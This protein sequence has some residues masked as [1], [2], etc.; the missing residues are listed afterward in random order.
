VGYQSKPPP[1]PSTDSTLVANQEPP[2]R[3]VNTEAPKSPSNTNGSRDTALPQWFEAVEQVGKF[4]AG[5]AIALYILG[6]LSVNGYLLGLG[7]SDFSLVRARFIYTG[8][9]E[10][11]T[12]AFGYFLPIVT[13]KKVRH[14]YRT[15]PP[16]LRSWRLHLFGPVFIACSIVIPV[17][18]ISLAL[19]VGTDSL[20]GSEVFYGFCIVNAGLIT[21]IFAAIQLNRIG[22]TRHRQAFERNTAMALAIVSLCAIGVLYA[23]VFMYL[24]YPRIPVQFGGGRPQDTR[25]LL[26]EEALDGA[27]ELGLPIAGTSRLTDQVK[28]MYEGSDSYVIRLDNGSIVQLKRNLI[29]GS[30]AEKDRTE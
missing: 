30:L 29:A 6:L 23:W 24:A 10:I 14:L 4:I 16:S 28:L 22:E 11:L 1:K 17:L 21:G 19:S 13:Y 25:L 8:S 2:T 27:K 18:F 3:G 5:L 26:T 20:K 12:L 9:L 15:I 7:V